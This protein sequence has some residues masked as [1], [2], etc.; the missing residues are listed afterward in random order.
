MHKEKLS[1][2][3]TEQAIC[4]TKT[5]KN[6]LEDRTLFVRSGRNISDD[7]INEIALKNS[8]YLTLEQ[9]K[10]KIFERYHIKDIV[11]LAII[12]ALALL[13]SAVMPLVIPLQSTIFGIAQLVTGLQLSIFPAIALM[14][15]RKVGSMFFISI[16]TGIVQLMMSPAMFVNNIIISIVL[17]LLAV[18][19][20]RGYKK[21][22]SVFFVVAL[23]NPLSLPFNYV[24]NSIIGN[25]IMTAVADKAPYMAVLMSIAVMAVSIIDTLIGIR[26]SKELA[27]A[28]ALKK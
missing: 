13:T 26:I 23:Y 2:F 25:E 16:F 7:E 17:E 1:R 22:I 12:S 5:S 27:K 8:R 20:F 14:K 10:N 3:A 6:K 24:Y 11:F 21:N 15:V 9:D 18:A 19:I 28:G 4:V